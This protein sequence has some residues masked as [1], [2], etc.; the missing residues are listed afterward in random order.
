MMKQK[1]SIFIFIL[2]LFLPLSYVSAG[3]VLSSYNYAWSNNAGY[4]NFE[5]VTVSDSALSGYA[6]S[7]NNGWIKFDPAQ[8][9]VLNDGTGN[10][11][12]SAWGESLGWIDFDGV[13][14]NGSTG[15]FSGT[16]TGE[17]V[18]T[19]NFDCPNYCDVRTD[20]Q[21]ATTPVVSSGGGSSGGSYTSISPQINANNVP[22]ILLPEQ[23]GTLTQDTP[24]GKIILEIPA[25]T[26]PNKTT[27]IIS[28][29]PL[30]QTNNYLVVGDTKLIN[31]LFYNI[32]AK[33]KNGND[34]HSFLNP[35]TITIPV[36]TDPAIAKN[37]AVYWLNETNWQWV[38]IPDAVFTYGKVS[39]KVTHLTKF[40]IFIATTNGALQVP[41]KPLPNLPL[42]I[43]KKSIQ[44]NETTNQ[45]DSKELVAQKSSGAGNEG[46]ATGTDKTDSPMQPA[47]DNIW[48]LA[49]LI[50]IILL[51]VLFV[52]FKHKRSKMK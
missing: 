1:W 18:G 23:S 47:S 24:A 40:A 26:V 41:T 43:N 25:S 34:L 36:P 15:I 21:Q 3:T 30:I 14:I 37:L 50:I 42:P 31:A 13:S 9:G 35:I 48:N 2:G 5:N 44:K 28:N 51:I 45:Q 33:D 6:W 4:I 8:G 20:W 10:L 16:A 11:S 12:G 17:L 22:L 19:I 7:A 46:T 49:F 39:F 32:S 52:I 27:F 38:L 29:E